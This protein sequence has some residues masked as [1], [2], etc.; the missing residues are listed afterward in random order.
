MGV[1]IHDKCKKEQAVNVSQPVPSCVCRGVNRCFC[2]QA[3]DGFDI[4]N[5]IDGKEQTGTMLLK[6]KEG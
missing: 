4:I 1:T 2:L 6:S 3:K 5:G